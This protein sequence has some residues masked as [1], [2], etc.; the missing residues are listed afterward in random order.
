MDPATQ[1]L[2]DNLA[3]GI[4]QH[5]ATRKFLRDEGDGIAQAK[6][7]MVASAKT[8]NLELKQQSDAHIKAMNAK[9]P[10]IRYEQ[11]VDLTAGVLSILS[12]SILSSWKPAY[13][14]M[15]KYH[16]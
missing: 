3:E 15:S 16:E 6:A 12:L 9:N 5:A 8:Q 7:D 10:E 1:Q 2:N 13:S 14:T 4:A 11:M